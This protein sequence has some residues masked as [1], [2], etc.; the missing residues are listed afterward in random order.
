MHQYKYPTEM[1]YR[2]YYKSNPPPYTTEKGARQQRNNDNNDACVVCGRKDFTTGY[3]THPNHKYTSILSESYGEHSSLAHPENELTCPFCESVIRDKYRSLNG[4]IMCA[5]YVK[6]II[7][8]T[9]NKHGTDNCFI[10]AKDIAGYLAEPPSPPF[11]MAFNKNA[12]GNKG[13]HFLQKGIINYSRD[14]YFITIFDE[15]IHVSRQFV[16][17]YLDFIHN[18][19]GDYNVYW[20]QSLY[21]SLL[22]GNN[23]SKVVKMF[24]ALAADMEFLTECCTN[25]NLKIIHL[26][27]MGQGTTKKKTNK[28][29]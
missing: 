28:K 15:Q 3:L 21:R 29:R 18:N 2:V 12:T 1:F 16:R 5:E 13:T 14:N 19:P 27:H 8:A 20:L 23:E 22:A 26:L 6:L 17:R 10:T 25:N 7:G 24:P 4:I 11:L 9:N